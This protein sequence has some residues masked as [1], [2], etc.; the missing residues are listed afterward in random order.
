MDGLHDND[1]FRD[2][3]FTFDDFVVG[4]FT[5]GTNAEAE[6]PH[7]WRYGRT[8]SILPFSV[9]WN[10]MTVL[11]RGHSNSVNAIAFSLD[12]QLIVSG[13]EDETV[14][15]W[16]APSSVCFNVEPYKTT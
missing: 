5:H 16:D 7:L 3:K 15:I 11:L 8:Y 4:V 14:R 12:G 9:V 13:S 10:P 6:K 1:R 2:W